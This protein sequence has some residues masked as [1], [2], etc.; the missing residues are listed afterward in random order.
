MK[1]LVRSLQTPGRC[2][3]DAHVGPGYESSGNCGEPGLVSE[4]VSAVSVSCL[5]V[6]M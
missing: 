6:G 1:G 5:G 3:D 2:W 4:P